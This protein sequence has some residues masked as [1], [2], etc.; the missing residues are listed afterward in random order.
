MGRDG[1][2]VVGDWGGALQDRRIVAIIQ[3]DVDP[4]NWRRLILLLLV[5]GWLPTFVL[6]WGSQLP[7]VIGREHC[8]FPI[9][10]SRWLSFLTAPVLTSRAMILL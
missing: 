3:L 10:V 4:S 5:N 7:V 2:C 8:Y 9:Q 6:R 1:G